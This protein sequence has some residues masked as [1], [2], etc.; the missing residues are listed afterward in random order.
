MDEREI[1]QPKIVLQL[2][3]DRF[4]NWTPLEFIVH[5]KFASCLQI[6]VSERETGAN[7]EGEWGE[8]VEVLKLGHILFD[9]NPVLSVVIIGVFHVF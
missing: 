6:V 9:E 4:L 8:W 2:P 3:L 1:I 5:L 7:A